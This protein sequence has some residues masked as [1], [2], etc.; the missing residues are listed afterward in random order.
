MTPSKLRRLPDALNAELQADADAARVR[1]YGSE[2]AA[3][4][5]QRVKEGEKMPVTEHQAEFAKW[6]GDTADPASEY[7]EALDA[8]A[9]RGGN[10]AKGKEGPER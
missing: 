2:D 10:R 3:T 6:I 1:D 4:Y 7:H 5:E 9:E 8:A